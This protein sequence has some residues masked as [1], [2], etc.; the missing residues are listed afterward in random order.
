MLREEVKQHLHEGTVIPAHP[1]A[2]TTERKLDVTRQRALTRYYIDAGVGG[3]AVGVHTTQ[4]E[5]RDP[6]F[7][8][9]EKVLTLAIDEMKRANVPQ[10]FIK[11]AGICGPV[12]QAL[13]EAEFAKRIG[14][15]LGLLSMGG[16]Q[17]LSEEA[18]LERTQKVAAIIPVIG[19]YLQPAVGGRRLTYD[20][21]KQLADIS[22]VHAIKIAPFNR[23][24]THDVVRAVCQSSRNEEIA[25]YTGND[26]TIVNDLLTT[27]RIDVDGVQVK[28]KIVGGL[29]GHWSVWTKRVVE[30]FEEIKKV[31]DYNQVPSE[32]LTL[33]QEITDANAAFFDV[34]NDFKGSIAG[35]NE[36]LTRQGILQGNWCLL[37]NEKLSPNQ[38][39]E[40]DRVYSAYPHLHDDDYVK[41]NINRWLE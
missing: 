37:E 33:G 11:I 7:N 15:D 14:Y 19:F 32:L 26:D 40:I 1:L 39:E 27:Y 16:L 34:A 8:L 31:R 6:K 29:L 17:N 12:E 38:L 18:L 24:L 25:L 41:E 10:R 21:W 3:L 28:K 9:F 35:I 13:Q 2:L 5:I 4:F 20:F 30:I 23:Y 36:V 22:N